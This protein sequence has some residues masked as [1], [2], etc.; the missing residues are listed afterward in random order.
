MLKEHGERFWTGDT[1]QMYVE[2]ETGKTVVRLNFSAAL[3]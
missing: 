2:D 1:W 3:L